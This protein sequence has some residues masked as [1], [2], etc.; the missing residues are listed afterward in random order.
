M[1]DF[2]AVDS[3]QWSNV[4]GVVEL[5]FCPPMS[6]GHLEQVL[7]QLK[8]VKVNRRICLEEDTLDQ[9]I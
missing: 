9:L 8:L 6:N 4:L 1:K 5:L 7:S 3:R 2:N